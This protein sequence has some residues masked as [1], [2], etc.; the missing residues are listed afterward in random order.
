MKKKLVKVHICPDEKQSWDTF[1]KWS[2]FTRDVWISEY[3]K[4][5][6]TALHP[7]FSLLSKL[8][9]KSILDCSCGFGFK[10]VMFAKMGYEAEGS[11]ASSIAI[12]YAPQLAKEQGVKIRF[13]C[14]FYKELGKICERRYDCVYSDYFDE[15][16]VIHI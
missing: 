8:N 7:L 11:D 9:V 3:W 5:T 6:E 1:W 15:I 10:T 4:K 14:S 13:F 12:K 16:K 2:W